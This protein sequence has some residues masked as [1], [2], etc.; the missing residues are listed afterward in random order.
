MLVLGSAF[1][2]M[3]FNNFSPAMST[4]LVPQLS[5]CLKFEPVR[6]D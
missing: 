2:G 4:P 6:G 3:A 5:E 1:R